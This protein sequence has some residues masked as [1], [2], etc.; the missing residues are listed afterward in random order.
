MMLKAYIDWFY[1]WDLKDIIDFPYQ[2][3]PYI[4]NGK[5]TKLN[6]FEKLVKCPKDCY[7]CNVCEQFF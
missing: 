1:H 3:V 4:D 2:N 6:F 5:L 7:S